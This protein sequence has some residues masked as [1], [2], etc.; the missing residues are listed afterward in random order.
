MAE[1]KVGQSAYGKIQQLSRMNL[2]NSVRVYPE[3]VNFDGQDESENIVLFLR[4]H[5]IVLIPTILRSIGIILLATMLT[6][7]F[8]TLTAQFG[9]MGT[10]SFVISVMGIALSITNFIY[11]LF[12]WYYTVTIITS[13]RLIDLDFDSVMDARWSTTVLRAIQDVSYNAPGFIN[14]LFDMASLTILTASHKENFELAN[15]PRARDVQDILMDLVENEKQYV[16]D[17]DSL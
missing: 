11:E 5:P 4:Q 3:R 2:F 1:I 17:D 16:P 7:A 6:W 12:K 8:S 14:T 13:T 10:V 9:S 15:L